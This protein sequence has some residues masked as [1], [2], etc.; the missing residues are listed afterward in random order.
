MTA[1]GTARGG[2]PA[3]VAAVTV[4]RDAGAA[5]ERLQTSLE[6]AATAPVP[7]LVADLGSTDGA[8][9]RAAARGA[10]VLR[11]RELLPHAAAVNRAVA[12]LHAEWVALTDPEVEWPEGALDALLAAAARHP[13]AG[14]LAP[15]LRLPDGA[16]R[17]SAFALPAVVDVLRGRPFVPE[18]RTEGPVGWLTTTCLLLRRAA[19]ESTDGPDA[20]HPPPYDA[21]DLGERLARAGWL[22]VTVPSV[23]VTVPARRP[24]WRAS[25]GRRYALTRLPRLARPAARV[26]L[27]APERPP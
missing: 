13:R 21:A 2:G 4:V 26:A 15:E 18:A 19:W 1:W 14:A 10:R 23:G 9:G 16:V 17:P 6:R 11:L 25:A 8:P 27:R 5:L 3:A 7:L 24:T 20:R 22:S 12:E